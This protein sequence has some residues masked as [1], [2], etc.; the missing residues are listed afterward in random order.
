MA[1]KR[2]SKKQDQV[3]MDALNASEVA[4]HEA[5]ARAGPIDALE[6]SP[7]FNA[8]LG[9]KELF[10]SNLLAWLFD[11]YPRVFGDT[12]AR[13]V[14]S[15]PG[16]DATIRGKVA[17]EYKHRD[18]TIDFANGQ[19]LVIENKVKSLPYIEQLAEYST[20]ANPNQHFLLLSLVR[21]PFARDGRVDVGNAVWNVITYANLADLLA[22]AKSAITDPYH[23]ALLDD[24]IGF[25][26]AFSDIFS[27]NEIRDNETFASVVSVDDNDTL[28]KLRALRIADVYQKLRCEA[29]AVKLYDELSKRYPGHAHIAVPAEKRLLDDVYVGHGMTNSTGLIEVSI[30]IAPGLFLT[31]QIQGMSYRHMAQ[32]YISKDGKRARHAADSLLERNLWFDFAH[33]GDGLKEYP[34]GEKRFNTYSN[35]D[36][37]RSVTIPNDMTVQRVIAAVVDDIVHVIASRREITEAL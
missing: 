13:F 30:V 23:A 26:R 33:I 37:Y 14:D 25:I 35:V 21:P 27:S 8:S 28:R 2:A 22:S 10:H 16:E 24:Y 20:D 4:W 34:R 15:K 11:S 6:M 5:M 19:Q 31:V 3:F 7:L 17:R 9:S 12:L 32:G 1:S 29:L 36:F 18:L